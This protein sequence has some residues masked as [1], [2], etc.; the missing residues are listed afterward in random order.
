MT[1]YDLANDLTIE[2]NV[3]I[4]RFKD[5][6]ETGLWEMKYTDDLGS[7]LRWIEG[8]EGFGDFEGVEDLKVNFIYSTKKDDGEAWL[9]IEVLEEE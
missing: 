2:G 3:E 4:K 1:L 7:S 5:D 8:F 6:I 9:V